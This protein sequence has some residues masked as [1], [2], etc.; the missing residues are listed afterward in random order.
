MKY[1]DTMALNNDEMHRSW[2]KKVEL[3]GH[4]T[5]EVQ[6]DSEKE[7]VRGRSGRVPNAKT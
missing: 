5:E 6:N 7:G 4:S 2:P 3:T 1:A